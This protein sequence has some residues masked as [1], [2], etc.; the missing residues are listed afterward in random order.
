MSQLCIYCQE[1]EA[2]TVDHVPPKC[3][4]PKPRSEL[5]TVPACESCNHQA[6]LD[7]EYFRSAIVA[8]WETDDLP[9]AQELRQIVFRSFERRPGW[10]EGWF[11]KTRF[12]EFIDEFGQPDNKM[13]YQMDYD[14]LARVAER[15]IRGLHFNEFGELLPKDC[16]ILIM[17]D[18]ALDN[19]NR[20]PDSK[21][22]KFIA[23]LDGGIART[24]H[25]DIFSYRRESVE[26]EKLTAVWLLQFFNCIWFLGLV[27]VR[28]KIGE[29]AQI[30]NPGADA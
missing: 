20:S 2:T 14:R 3:L 25:E 15:I 6:S 22:D 28:G 8:R 26:G 23:S 19:V 18:W 21:V 30:V 27:N 17:Q 1:R 4:F 11:A 24:I 10:K 12:V 16:P 7:D 5:I 29:P 9:A 13:Q